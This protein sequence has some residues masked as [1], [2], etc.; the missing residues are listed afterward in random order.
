VAYNDEGQLEYDTAK[1]EAYPWALCRAYAK[2]L[3][4]QLLEDWSENTA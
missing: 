2:G 3:K 1:E 4:Q